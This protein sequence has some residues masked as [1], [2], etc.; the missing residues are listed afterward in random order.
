M[1]PHIKGGLDNDRVY[2]IA[3]YYNDN[4]KERK[5]KKFICVRS[6]WDDTFYYYCDHQNIYDFLKTIE[7]ADADING[8]SFSYNISPEIE[9][10]TLTIKIRGWFLNT[11]L[12]LYA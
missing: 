10:S 9:K 1:K 3:L 6:V 7:F 4:N 2:K 11:V 8:Y 5:E 12:T